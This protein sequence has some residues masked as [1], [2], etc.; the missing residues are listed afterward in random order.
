MKVEDVLAKHL[1]SIGTKEKRA[2]IKNQTMFFNVQFIIKNSASVGNGK[3]ILFS[4]GN[5]NLWG[6]NLNSNDYPTDKFSYDGKNAKIGYIRPGFRSILGGFIVS[7]NELLEDGLLGGTL[8]SSWTLLNADVKKSKIS[9][10]GTKEIDGNETFVLSYLPKGGSDLNIKM[11]FDKQNYRH[12]RTDYNRIIAA[13]Q[14]QTVDGSAGQGEDRYRLTEDFSNFQN[15]GGLTLPGTYR[16]FYS[17]TSTAA[18]RLAQNSNREIEYKFNLTNFSYNQRVEQNAF[19]ID[20][21]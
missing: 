14:G 18:L 4:E 17:H 16:L 20:A 7:Y 9:F 19:D 1:D 6:V 15:M 8:A 3:A 10:E 21:K 11:Y 13:R 2:E 12:V 5:K